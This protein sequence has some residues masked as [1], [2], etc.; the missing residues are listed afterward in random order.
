MEINFITVSDFYFL[1]ILAFMAFITIIAVPVTRW[2][3]WANKKKVEDDI[4]DR[5]NRDYS[6]SNWF[7]N[8]DYLPFYIISIA[9]GIVCIL[10]FFISSLNVGFTLHTNKIEEFSRYQ[11]YI[12]SKNSY[13]EILNMSTD[14]INTPL[15]EEVVEYNKNLAEIKAKYNDPK[16]DMNFS[17]EYDWNALEYIELKEK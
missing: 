14:I 4:Y 15:Y 8:D 16:F 7:Y 5:K 12:V 3:I 6:F 17:G 2:Q 10:S 1:A 9:T 13:E 11:T